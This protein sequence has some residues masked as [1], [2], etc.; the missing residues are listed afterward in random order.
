MCRSPTGRPSAGSAADRK[1]ADRK[2]GPRCGA[3]GKRY[4]A[5]EPG[6]HHQSGA[7]RRR[8]NGGGDL[9]LLATPVAA[10]TQLLRTAGAGRY[11][12]RPPP[13]DGELR[14][15]SR[16]RRAAVALHPPLVVP[17]KEDASRGGSMR[18]RAVRCL[19]RLRAEVRA[20]RAASMLRW[21]PT[22]RAADLT[23]P[24]LHPAQVNVT[25]GD[26]GGATGIHSF[27][28]TPRIGKNQYFD[29]GPHLMAR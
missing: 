10:L 1:A 2:T 9:T 26:E 19:R 7:R 18:R 23:E 21:T 28:V 17:S 3:E 13:S 27:R 15:R 24:A 25:P 20:C 14:T 12:G 6:A 5:T 16:A 22:H 11:L 29:C 8:E 4:Q